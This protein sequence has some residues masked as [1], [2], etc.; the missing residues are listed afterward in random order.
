MEH[1]SEREGEAATLQTLLAR[2]QDLEHR[3]L[4]LEQRMRELNARLTE[5]E[6]EQF[7]RVEQ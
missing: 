4:V 1:P 2:Q 7:D 6:L 3:L 5:D